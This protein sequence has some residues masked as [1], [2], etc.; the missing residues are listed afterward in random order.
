MKST[1]MHAEKSNPSNVGLTNASKHQYWNNKRR[2]SILTQ[3]KF[4]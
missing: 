4:I 1:K 2:Y 3:Y